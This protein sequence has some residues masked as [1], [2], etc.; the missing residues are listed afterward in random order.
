MRNF[1]SLLR[2]LSMNSMARLASYVCGTFL[3]ALATSHCCLADIAGTGPAFSPLS[4]NENW[5]FHKGDIPG[6]EKGSFDD[7]TWRSVCLPHDWAIEGPFDKKYNARCGG[8]P[9]HGTGWYRK[10][11]SV[12]KDS[13]GQVVT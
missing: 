12:T 10:T 6:A 2:N 9:F 7:S 13:Q 11:F 3:I 8:L 4:F 1:R 5:R